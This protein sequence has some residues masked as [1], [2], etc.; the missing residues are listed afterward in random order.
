MLCTVQL[1]RDRPIPNGSLPHHWNFRHLYEQHRHTAH[2]HGREWR[3]C[4]GHGRVQ[5]G[6]AHRCRASCYG[7][8]GCLWGEGRRLE[9]F[10]SVEPRYMSLSPGV[11][12]VQRPPPA[13]SCLGGHM[14][15]FSSTFSAPIS[16]Y[17]VSSL[18]SLFLWLRFCHPLH[19]S[20]SLWL[21]ARL[22]G[23]GSR[24]NR[25]FWRLHWWIC[26]GE[27]LC[28]LL[29]WRILTLFL[30]WETMLPCASGLCWP[31]SASPSSTSQGCSSHRRLGQLQGLSL[32]LSGLS[33]CV[34]KS[35]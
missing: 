5:G 23:L 2:L 27:C 6:H 20:C 31:C 11:S 4:E 7:C 10:R 21:L 9:T 15:Y 16:F 25:P 3:L 19:T 30:S 14:G 26:P 8:S 12:A 18:S 33:P 17:K 35:N 28:D 32:I 29:I 22:R 34:L 24:T 1:Q 13:S